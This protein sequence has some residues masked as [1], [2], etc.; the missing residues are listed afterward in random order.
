MIS[1]EEQEAGNSCPRREGIDLQVVPHVAMFHV[2]TPPR[3]V[4]Q[5][6]FWIWKK[7]P[8]STKRVAETQQPERKVQTTWEQNRC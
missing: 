3:E 7:A 5:T 4:V 8:Q 1:E 6:H 2:H